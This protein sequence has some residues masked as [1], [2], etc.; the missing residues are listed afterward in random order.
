MIVSIVSVSAM[1]LSR[2]D[3]RSANAVEKMA[4]ARLMAQSAVEYALAK[5][6]AN[7]AWRSTYTSGNQY[8]TDWVNLGGSGEFKFIL[9]DSDGNLNDDVNDAV[10]LRGIGRAGEAV[11]L[12]TVR[13]EPTGDPL[14][15]LEVSLCVDGDLLTSSGG[16]LV[17]DQI[18]SS[19]AVVDLDST[20]ITGD[21]DAVDSISGSITGSTNSGISPREMPHEHVFEYYQFNGTWVDIDDV[22]VDGSSDPLISSILLSPAVNPFG[23]TNPA[24]IYVIDCE[25]KDLRIEDCRIVG[26]IVLLNPGSSTAL[27]G[28]VALEPAVPNFP[29]LLVQGDIAILTS[30]VDLSESALGVNF[31]PVG[32]P[33]DDVEDADQSDTYPSVAEGVI[34][35]S[36]T[37]KLLADALHSHFRGVVVCE[38]IVVASEATFEYD[39]VFFDNPP[40]GF[41][42]GPEWRVMP[43]SW[44]RVS[45]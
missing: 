12:A 6:T 21:V 15:C 30:D 10:T 24:G 1:H 33:S 40:P 20:T 2:L 7:S 38:Q 35:V 14:A 11:H 4:K 19:N 42:Q 13:L 8:P 45:N 41:A 25:G 28:S 29:G 9:S 32:T 37:L 17:T 26:T 36:G 3:R 22:P 43:A 5:I 39:Q 18:I 44:E 16:D 34:Y 27:A 31:N 23:V